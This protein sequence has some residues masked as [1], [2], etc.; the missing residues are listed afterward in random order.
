MSQGDAFTLESSM[1]SSIPEEVFSSKQ[2]S[3]QQDTN[4]A[5]NPSQLRFQL[6]GFRSSD[7]F[8]NLR[9]GYMTIPLILALSANGSAGITGGIADSDF[10]L[11]MKTGFHQVI[12]SMSVM[13]DNKEVVQINQNLSQYVSY[14]LM[15]SMSVDDVKSN[16]SLVCPDSATSWGFSTYTGGVPSITSANGIGLYN[17]T[18]TPFPYA[19]GG[20]V[21]SLNLN[22]TAGTVGASELYNA[23]LYA[24]TQTAV[25]Q[26][27]TAKYANLKSTSNIQAEAK[28]YITIGGSGA[29]QYVA[30]YLL[31]VIKLKDIADIFDKMPLVRGVNCSL[32]VNL[33]LGHAVIGKSAGGLVI[34]SE[35]ASPTT[36]TVAGGVAIENN[37]S[38][39]FLV[40]K[41]ATD[42]GSAMTTAT[43]SLFAGLHY[44]S[45]R[46]TGVANQSGLSI[47]AHPLSVARIYAPQIALTPERALQYL[48]TSKKKTVVYKDYLYFYQPNIGAGSSFNLQLA[49]SINNMK[50]LVVI[51]AIASSFLGIRE[52]QSPFD[53]MPWTTS[54]LSIYNFNAQIASQNV[55]QQNELYGYEQFIHE[56]DGCNAIN[57]GLTTGLTSGLV[58][59]TAWDN[60]Y[61]YYVVDLGRRLKDD[62]LG[63]SLSVLGNNNNSIAMDLHCF[64]EIQKTM[65]IDVESGIV[66]AVIA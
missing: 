65:V 27:L 4:N 34:G 5:N 47:P 25:K 2:W 17:N 8:V 56:T 38:M 52:D 42:W 37:G 6:D 22:T 61:K 59:F 50:S 63:K 28:N 39:P 36:S 7:K 23:G 54:P 15:T 14:K 41:L 33:Q 3:Y 45:V 30:Q 62:V 57:G 21:T 58:D 60:I 49:P 29:T 9:E 10:A 24:R 44:S 18:A 48:T 40:N 35:I 26:S 53:T 12:Q 43:G 16:P 55:F 66:D 20:A 46:A 51:P 1:S 11:A 64:V 32:L 19:S 31:A 13:V